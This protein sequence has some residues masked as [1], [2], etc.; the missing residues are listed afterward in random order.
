MDELGKYQWV[1]FGMATLLIVAAVVTQGALPAVSEISEVKA[2]MKDGETKYQTL[3]NKKQIL[4]NQDVASFSRTEEQLTGAI[5]KTIDLPLILTTLQRAAEKVEI[6]LGEFALSS[7]AASVTVLP[8]EGGDKVSTFR[9]ELKLLGSLE[10]IE[11]FIVELARVSP[12]I[13]V[14]S[15]AFSQTQTTVRIKTFFQSQSLPEKTQPDTVLVA[16]SDKHTEAI[17]KISQLAPPV[18][19]EEEVASQ[20]ATPRDNPF[21]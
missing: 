21:R 1:L 6:S 12:L 3:I 13:Q 19:E 5:P 11:Q 17:E 18:L 14:E 9:F 4:Q 2:R 10:K 7:K 8:I 16:L 15:I 20:E